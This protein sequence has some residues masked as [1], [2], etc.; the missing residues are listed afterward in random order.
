MKQTGLDPVAAY[1]DS[2]DS[3]TGLVLKTL[4]RLIRSWQPQLPVELWQ[5]MGYSIIGYGRSSYRLRSGQKNQWFIVGLA[6]HKSYFSLYLWGSVG[7][8]YLLDVYAGRLG[9]VKTGKACLNFKNLDDLDTKTLKEA[10][11]KA[12]DL[13]AGSGG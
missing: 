12:V 4:D 13:Q 8:R 3:Q 2:F 1:I 11:Q 7:D 6:A 9:R 10:V 5:S